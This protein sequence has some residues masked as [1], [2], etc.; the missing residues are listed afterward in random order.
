MNDTK[1]TFPK[2][3]LVTLM[4]TYLLPSLLYG[5]IARGMGA[6]NQEEFNITLADPVIYLMLLLQVACPLAT[7]FFFSRKISEYDGSEQAV[8]RTNK[9]IGIFEKVSIALPVLL[10]IAVPFIYALRYKQRGLEYAAFMENSPLLYEVTLM[11]G[12]TFCFSLCTYIIFMQSIERSIDKVLYRKEFQTM[13]LIQRSVI[14]S[15]FGLV[16][17]ACI[18]ESMLFIPANRD[19]PNVTLML[20]ILP[21]ALL[22]IIMDVIDFYFTNRD[23]K[24]SIDNVRKVTSA[25]YNRDYKIKHIPVLMRCE[26]GELINELNAFSNT[27]N[28][29]MV[30]FRDVIDSTRENAGLLTKN[31]DAAAKSITDITTG[32]DVIGN[33]ISTQAAGVE[34]SNASATHIMSTIK[35]LN[36]SIE[37]QAASVNSSSA[38]VDEMVANIRSMTT[39]LEKNTAAVNS[40]S[41]ASDEGRNS[42]QSAVSMAD[43][44]LSQSAALMDA[45]SIIQTIASQTNLLAM[46]AAIESA[47]AGEAGKGFAVVADEIRKLAEQSS[48]QGKAIDTS[49]KA[50]SSSIQQ[51]SESTK[52]VQ[53]KFDVIYTMAQTVREQEHVIMNA[54][55]E[56][57][58][59]NQQVLDAMHQISETTQVVK[60][61]S[62]EMLAGGEQIVREMQVLSDSTTKIKEKM[63]GITHNISLISKAMDDVV[64]GND[65]NFEETGELGVI[66]NSFEL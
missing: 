21:F 56:Q 2:R 47:H 44:I 28:E 45:S 13:G 10:S 12:I 7:Y 59:G 25:L 9:L 49:L 32:I 66:I 58:E 16:G 29:V 40:L 53:K 31:L 36:T 17:L 63:D 55:K 23:I 18:V 22:A 61:G 30:G 62:S 11:I 38:A 3:T 54:M 50:L 35:E 15:G 1:I 57:S 37:N 14:M 20:K 41:S 5:F 39:I 8:V 42:V 60:D 64:Q 26:L 24:E 65:K 43:D 19:L 4:L 48:D 52:E 6:I 33:E 46:N 34:E 51:V 27:T